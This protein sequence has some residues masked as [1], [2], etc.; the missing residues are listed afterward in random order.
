MK[1][2]LSSADAEVYG[3][4]KLIE[5]VEDAEPFAADLRRGKEESGLEGLPEP[6]RIRGIQHGQLHLSD[7]HESVG[8]NLIADL[9]RHVQEPD[10]CGFQVGRSSH[11]R[12]KAVVTGM[13]VCD[14]SRNRIWVVNSGA[15]SSPISI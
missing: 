4:V 14:P 13:I 15:G 11:Q 7:A 10:G 12:A 3:G 8:V 2:G 1:A 5:S 9:A 6:D